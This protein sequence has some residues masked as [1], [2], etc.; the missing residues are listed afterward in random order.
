M[1]DISFYSNS[2]NE[3]NEIADNMYSNN[4]SYY[5]DD[6]RALQARLE[7]KTH[8]ITDEELEWVLTT[9]PLSLFSAAE[10]LNRV[11]LEQETIK[12]ENKKVKVELAK[13]ETEKSPVSKSDLLASK[14]ADYDIVLSIYGSVISRV[15][16][17]LTFCKELIMGCKKIWDGRRNAEK[18]N[19]IAPV[20]TEELPDYQK[21]VYIK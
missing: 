6:V 4:F 17:E 2:V 12:L 16:S 3:V 18:S 11:K 7:S 13:E 20:N 1:V 19:P 9:L 14:M 15:E 5:F 8:P 21:D 10:A